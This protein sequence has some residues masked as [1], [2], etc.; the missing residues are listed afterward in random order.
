MLYPD[1]LSASYHSTGS[2]Q[3]DRSQHNLKTVDWEVKNQK[4][5]KTRAMFALL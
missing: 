2:T 4:K 3:E 1:T 5:Q